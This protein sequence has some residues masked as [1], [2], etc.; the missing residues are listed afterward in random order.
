MV[1]EPV[2]T[3]AAVLFDVDGVLL[4]SGT[5]YARVW[6]R[7]AAMH[8]LDP[9]AVCAF[10]QGR[11]MD[12]TLRA[13]LPHGD[14]RAER[15]ILDGFMAEHRD[16][17]RPFEGAV[18]LLASLP[19][20]RWAIATSG[21]RAAVRRRFAWAGLPMPDVQVCAADVTRGKPDPECYAAA[22]WQLGTDPAQCLVVD[23]AP[24]GVAAGQAAGCSVYAVST[25]HP[26]AGLAAADRCYDSLAA[27]AD[28]IQA[29]AS[30]HRGGDRQ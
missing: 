19:E 23:D 17:V 25:T 3:R 20:G 7:W 2:D 14:H 11:R 16:L 9:R 21:R 13:L 12:D 30:A 22:A 8:G 1:R 10:T 29:W 24:A 5:A 26:A 4:D 6:S 28:D 18:S 15:G 27:A